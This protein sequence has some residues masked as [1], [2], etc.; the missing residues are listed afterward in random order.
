M[1]K[2]SV[3]GDFLAGAL[4]GGVVGIVAGILYAPTAGE[5]TRTQLVEKGKEYKGVASGKAM[6]KS[7]E[8]MMATK[9]LITTLKERFKNSEEIQRVLDEVNQGISGE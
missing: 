5:E 2:L 8:A 9:E 4:V 1:N 7:Q 6:E 3:K